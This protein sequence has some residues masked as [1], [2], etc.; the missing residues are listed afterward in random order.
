MET[1]FYLF[2]GLAN[3]RRGTVISDY[4]SVKMLNSDSELPDYG[5]LMMFGQEW[6]TY[7]ALQQASLMK[8]LKSSGRGILLI[9]PFNTEQLANALDWQVESASGDKTATVAGLAS[10]LAD[11]TRFQFKAVSHQFSREH[12]HNWNDDSLNTLYY[13]PHSSGGVFAATALPLWSLTCLD[14]PDLVQFWLASLYG[15]AGQVK[16]ALPVTDK[17]T[18]V[19]NDKHLALLCCAYGHRFTDANALVTRVGRLG[20][21]R[22]QSTELDLAVAELIDENLFLNGELTEKGLNAILASP[23]KL[24][25]DELKRMPG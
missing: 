10:S 19:L 15:I 7:T 9:P 12:A 17:A 20:V 14:I 8:W 5:M 16:E 24:Y 21:F 6:Q 25:A 11:E 2:G 4:L 18:L 1:A 22:F 13:K 23:Y 3:H